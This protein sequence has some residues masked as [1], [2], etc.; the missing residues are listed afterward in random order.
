MGHIY[1]RSCHSCC[2]FAPAAS[3]RCTSRSRVV[4]LV[5]TS[6]PCA[7]R[8]AT[9]QAL[10]LDINS[11]AALVILYVQLVT[12]LGWDQ[13]SAD[14]LRDAPE[15]VAAAKHCPPLHMLLGRSKAQRGPAAIFALFGRG[16]GSS[17]SREST[18]RPNT[19]RAAT[20]AINEGLAAFHA[21]ERCF[22]LQVLHGLRDEERRQRTCP[23]QA[24]SCA[25]ALNVVRAPRTVTA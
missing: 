22:G 21:D 12:E 1:E 20:S 18:S 23:V 14:A 17:H 25:C 7:G 15:L 11:S 4:R 19:L 13:W 9:L 8:R 24:A 2:Q 10:A 6:Q 3:A 5:C 16:D